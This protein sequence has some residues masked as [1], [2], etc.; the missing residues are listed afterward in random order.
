MYCKKCGSELPEGARFCISCGCDQQS[1][2]SMPARNAA[3]RRPDNYLWLSILVTLF[4]CMPFGIV[5]IIYSSK[6]DSY[7]DSGDTASAM[8]SSSKAKSWALWGLVLTVIF[9]IL[10][11]GLCVLLG[12]SVLDS[13][14][15]MDLFQELNPERYTCC[16]V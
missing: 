4:C 1:D 8:R 13:D 15:L 5:G 3:A 6:T 9:W 16:L 10:Y 11:I 7:F 12:M 14:F 2:L